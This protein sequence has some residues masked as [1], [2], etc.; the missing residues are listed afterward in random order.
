VYFY[1]WDLKIVSLIVDSFFES[2]ESIH[3]E[4]FLSR[5]N[6]VDATVE[7]EKCQTSKC[8]Q[9]AKSAGHTN[10]YILIQM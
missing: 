9:L 6:N 4:S 1:E 10:D 7:R 2:S 8:E 5:I 3:D